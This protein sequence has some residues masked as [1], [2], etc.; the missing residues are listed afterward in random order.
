MKRLVIDFEN[1]YEADRVIESAKKDA[2][3]HTVLMSLRS[4]NTEG[5]RATVVKAEY[6]IAHLSDQLQHMRDGIKALQE[7]GFTMKLLRAF[8]KS[9]GVTARAMD[10]VLDGI[11]E[12]F[13]QIK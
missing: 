9:K 1:D 2:E 13:Y 3:G 4:G 11:D 10:A 5:V 7:N 12:F 8:L 6:Q